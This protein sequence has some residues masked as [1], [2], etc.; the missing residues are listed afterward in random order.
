MLGT[1]FQVNRVRDVWFGRPPVA[2]PESF[3]HGGFSRSGSD[4]LFEWRALREISAR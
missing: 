3:L 2:E 4:R 1:R